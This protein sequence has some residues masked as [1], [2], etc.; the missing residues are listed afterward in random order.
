MPNPHL[1]DPARDRRLDLSAGIASVTVASVL[2]VLKL[3]ALAQTGSLSVATAMADSALDLV[4]SLGGLAAIIYA[5]RPPDEDHAFGHH[6]AEDIAA[7]TQSALVLI[8]AGVIAVVAILRML[9]PAPPPLAAEGAGVVVMLASSVITLG[10]I[11]WQMRVVR[12]T[13]SRVV[14]ADSLH[15]LGDLVPNLGAALALVASGLWGFVR[16][17][18]VVALLGAVLMV[19]GAVHVL[20]A[21]FDALMDRRA[22]PAMIKRISTIAD[23]FPGV[24]GWHDLRTRVSGRQ[25][26][27]NL[28]VELDG[29]QTL[30]EA[31]EICA[32]LRRAIVAA[33]PQADVMIH[34]DP[35]ENTRHPDDTRPK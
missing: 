31:H 33:L 30:E 3:W 25:I 24:L 21:A 11:L 7:L 27:V 12:I 2:V 22:D 5:T 17:D 20:K 14:A 26:F 32:A 29:L 4:M 16:I 19:S 6:A 28:H 15:Y 8:S 13:G 18:A 34:A 35:A 1:P 10:L 9:N 23:A